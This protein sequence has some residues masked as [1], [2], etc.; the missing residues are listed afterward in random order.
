[1][2]GL[3]FYK[4]WCEYM[5][6]TEAPP[7]YSKWIALS[8]VAAVLKRTVWLQ[9]D[10]SLYPNMYILLIGP[11]GFARK[12]TAMG[13]A[14]GLLSKLSVEVAAS[15][16]TRAALIKNL[17]KAGDKGS[18]VTDDG[19]S[20]IY[21]ALTVFSPEF[22]VFIG[23]NNQQ[24]MA[25]LADWY[26]CPTIW[27]YETI[28]R[29][30]ERLEGV[31]LNLIGATTPELLQTT[32][33]QDAVGG[34]LMSRVIPVWAEGRPRPVFPFDERP[35]TELFNDLF[36]ALN[37][38]AFSHG[39][40]LFDESF[41]TQ[42]R[43]WYPNQ[44]KEL[45]FEEARLQYY[46]ARRPTHLL[47]AAMCLNASRGG[48][49]LLTSHDFEV[50]LELLKETEVGME[51]PFAGIGSSDTAKVKSDILTFIY[52]NKAVKFSKILR[53]FYKDLT[54]KDQLDE[55]LATMNIMGFIEI[56]VKDPET[57]LA[58]TD[59]IVKYKKEDK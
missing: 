2:K 45:D 38:I 57:G 13:P 36:G 56:D 48:D 26:D 59:Y 28:S 53:A 3:D 49:K 15:S 37:E 4:G 47:K 9:W 30:E 42:W 22:T 55:I 33:P 25:D 54:S 32:L 17:K 6:A 8:M 46:A 44:H 58:T 14:K 34:G 11:A 52:R 24:L 1:M 19:G 40:F 7:L 31:Y 39:E 29:S 51:K 35:D 27:N 20:Y 10:K 5:S 16:T 23:Y 12:G 43:K 18:F 21:S 41:K 50:A